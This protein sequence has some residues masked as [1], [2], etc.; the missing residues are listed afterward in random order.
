M[1][2]VGLH[3][4]THRL[5]SVRNDLT[6]ALAEIEVPHDATPYHPHITIGRV[7][8]VA[9]FKARDLP[10]RIRI[11]FEELMAEGLGTMR[12]PID[13]P[14][15]E[16]LLVRSVIDHRGSTYDVIG[17]YP[18]APRHPG[19]VAEPTG[20]EAEASADRRKR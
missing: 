13:I 6:A 10:D 4:P 7:R 14:I 16:V 19:R 18:L 8:S 9:N 3:G 20:L 2:W 5:E 12:Q 11:R 1:L 17:R 15:D